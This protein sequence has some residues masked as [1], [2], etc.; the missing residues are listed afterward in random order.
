MTWQA[1]KLRNSRIAV[2]IG[3]IERG[4]QVDWQRLHQLQTLDLIRAG[5][6]FLADAIEEERSADER[7]ASFLR[8]L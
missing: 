7:A 8:N 1:D 3:Q 4:E 5:E 2:A 6:L